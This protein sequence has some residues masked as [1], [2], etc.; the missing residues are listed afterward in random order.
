MSASENASQGETTVWQTTRVPNLLR[1]GPSGRYYAR[2]QVSGK[3]KLVSLQTGFISVAR[4]N[5]VNVLDRAAVD[6]MRGN[7]CDVGTVTM[8]MLSDLFPDVQTV[9]ASPAPPRDRPA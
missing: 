3:R 5:L 6:Q 4:K 2:I 9:R 7:S 8:G 1:H